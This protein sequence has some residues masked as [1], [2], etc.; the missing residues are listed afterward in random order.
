[1]REEMPSTEGGRGT[2][3]PGEVGNEG[4]IGVDAVLEPA[5]AK[6]ILVSVSKRCLVVIILLGDDS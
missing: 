3:K 4:E 6:P 2:S 5:M 1:M